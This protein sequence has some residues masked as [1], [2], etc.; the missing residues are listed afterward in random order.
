MDNHQFEWQF[1]AID[2]PCSMANCLPNFPVGKSRE[3]YTYITD[4]TWSIGESLIVCWPFLIMFDP[5]VMFHI[6]LPLI[7][8][9]YVSL[10]ED[11]QN[12]AL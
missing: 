10:P 6:F 5:L 7:S 4:V 2:G 8:H 9:S 12:I 11:I 3:I 1:L